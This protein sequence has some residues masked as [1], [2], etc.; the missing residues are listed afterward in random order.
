MKSM[1][2][3]ND[4]KFIKMYLRNSRPLENH[5]LA[6]MLKKASDNL[7]LI[8]LRT[9]LCDIKKKQG[10]NDISVFSTGLL[11]L[12]LS[13][14]LIMSCLK[15]NTFLFLSVFVLVRAAASDPRVDRIFPPINE[16][17]DLSVSE[18]DKLL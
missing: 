2:A 13:S 5:K 4:K 16:N 17:I 1:M 3:T 10:T 6:N 8:T 14:R 15:L 9:S 11:K 7:S 18:H 12:S